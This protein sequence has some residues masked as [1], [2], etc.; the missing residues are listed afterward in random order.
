MLLLP[1][2]GLARLRDGA[3]ARGSE[4]VT[5]S[6]SGPNGGA[7]LLPRLL[8]TVLSI[9]G[10]VKV[11]YSWVARERCSTCKAEA[12]SEAKDRRKICLLGRSNQ[13]PYRI[14]SLGSGSLSGL[15]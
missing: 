7:V 1:S 4:C 12:K 15:L 6:A 14:G 11:H 2:E 13:G 9:G 10:H 3:W 8:A 5:R